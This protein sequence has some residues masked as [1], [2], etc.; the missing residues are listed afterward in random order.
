QQIL[1]QIVSKASDTAFGK[2]HDFK[3]IRNYNDFKQRVPIRDY[4]SARPYFDRV[5]KAE[6]DVL[7]PGLPAYF[8]KTSGTT[9]GTK[10]IPITKDSIPNHFGSARDMTFQYIAQSGKA[11]FF[12][13]KMIFLSGSPELTKTNGILTGRLSGISNHMIPGWVKSGGHENRRHASDN[14]QIGARLVRDPAPRAHGTSQALAV[15]DLARQPPSAQ[16]LIG[17]LWRRCVF[18]RHKGI[19]APLNLQHVERPT[20]QHDPPCADHLAIKRHPAPTKAT[21]GPR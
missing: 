17:D 8:A 7:W 12:D 5:V 1:Q 14:A 10:Y 21:F 20:L 2:D 6:Q 4:E 18:D 15:T 3:G 9:S 16:I 11:D 13:G 19:P